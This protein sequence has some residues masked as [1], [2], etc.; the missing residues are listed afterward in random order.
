MHSTAI[1]SVM[2]LLFARKHTQFL[3]N[4]AKIDGQINFLGSLFWLALILLLHS[5]NL[6]YSSWT[7]GDETYRRW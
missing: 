2:R 3:V 5:S 6:L 1:H 4:L 7:H